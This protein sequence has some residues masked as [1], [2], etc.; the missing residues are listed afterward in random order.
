MPGIKKITKA[1]VQNA[2]LE[3]LRNEGYESLNVRKISKKLKCST[4]P[5]Y[6]AFK[7][8]DELKNSL[9]N[10]I[11]K[12]FENYIDIY[13]KKYP[14]YLARGMAVV[15]FA[16]ND[17]LLYRYFFMSNKTSLIKDYESA[18][19]ENVYK[20][21]HDSYGIDEKH[22]KQIHRN[23]KYYTSGLAMEVNIGE[24]ISEEEIGQLLIGEFMRI[25]KEIKSQKE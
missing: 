16:K 24:H 4:Q 1:D 21:L 18:M 3:I 6:S 17:K 20:L 14:T 12:I 10:E 19:N 11:Y 7:S 25:I 2:A 5:V 15:Q 9:L 23:I 22:A 13:A 8:M